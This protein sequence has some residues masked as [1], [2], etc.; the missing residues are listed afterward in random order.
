MVYQYKDGD[1]IPLTNLSQDSMPCGSILAW[2]TGTAPTGYLI[3]DGSTFDTS[4]Y[5]MLYRVLGTNVLP[6]LREVTLVGAG[7]NDTLSIATHDVYTL[8]EFK[9]DQFQS[10]THSYTDYGISNT[11]SGISGGGLSYTAGYFSAWSRTTGT[12]SGRTGTTTH[13][14]QVGVNWI[15]KATASTEEAYSQSQLE[16][17]MLELNQV[18][19]DQLLDE[20]L[21]Y[22]GQLGTSLSTAYEC[23]YD[24]FI[25]CIY[26]ATSSTTGAIG[27]IYVVT[28]DG[29]AHWYKTFA[30]GHSSYGSGDC[31][32]IPVC[33]GWKLYYDSS[34]GSDWSS[35]YAQW[36]SQRDYS[37]R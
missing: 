22:I 10:H 26:A 16:S 9:D 7:E 3:C 23:P 6:D 15:I 25:H 37:N 13:G 14:K 24:G 35:P 30:A 8:G 34:Y 11:T 20:D 5:P 36:Y 31:L 27:N 18:K 21:T 17:L 4:T 32:V 19:L 1:F 29:T 12:P 33:K 28:S 2:Y